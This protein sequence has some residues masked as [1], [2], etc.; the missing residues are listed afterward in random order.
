MSAAS[1]SGMRGKRRIANLRA[2]VAANH[3]QGPRKYSIRSLALRTGRHVPLD[4]VAVVTA[5]LAAVKRAG[6]QLASF[7]AARAGQ[8]WSVRDPRGSEAWDRECCGG[9]EADVGRPPN[10][11]PAMT[12]V[13]INTTTTAKPSLD[14]PGIA[15]VFAGCSIGCPVSRTGPPPLARRIVSA[16]HAAT[17]ARDRHSSLARMCST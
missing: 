14:R 6:G 17:W 15:P 11:V 10:A 4:P 13:T 12:V 1:M 7:S 2:A 8:G 16:N 3:Q 5:R 9:A